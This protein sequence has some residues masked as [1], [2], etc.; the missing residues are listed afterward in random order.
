MLIGVLLY[1]ACMVVPPPSQ[2][3]AELSPA[4][5]DTELY[6]LFQMCRAAWRERTE[7]RNTDWTLNYLAD[8]ETNTLVLII[9]ERHTL[10]VVFRGS[11]M[12]RSEIDRRFNTMIVRRKPRFGRLPPNART[13]IGFSTK[14]LGVREQV[15]EAVSGSTA[16]RI[17]TVG[18]SA[19]GALATL[20]FVDLLDLEPQRMAYAVTFGAPR[21]FN[22]AG[23]R[24]LKEYRQRIIR[25]VNG[26]DIVP[27]LPSVLLGYRHVGQVIEISHDTGLRFASQHDHDIGYESALRERARAAGADAQFFAPFE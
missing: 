26:A 3:T 23:A 18:H 12:R 1:G 2:L 8:Q 25:V 13:H 5:D 22:R 16:R 4:V 6:R 10:F 14:Y 20:A 19:G 7:Y 24:A 27:R 11:Q 9:E 21:V 15:K 17:V